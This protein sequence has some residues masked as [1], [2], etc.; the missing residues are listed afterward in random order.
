MTANKAVTFTFA[1]LLLALSALVATRLGSEFVPNLNEGDFAVLTVR[2]PGTSLTQSVTM[3]QQI[4]TTLKQR[5]PEIASVFARTGT[6]EIAS[7][8]MPPNVSDGYIM[9]K[10]ER[11]WPTPKKTREQLLA[12]IQQT[13]EQLPGN[14][15]EF[16]QPIQL[17]VNELISGVRSD[18]AIK[19]FGDDLAVLDKTAAKIAA[20][21]EEVAG[22]S[23]VKVEQSSGLPMLQIRIDRERAARLGLNMLDVQ[24]MIATATAG[25]TAGSL[26]E[27]D[28]RFD[29]TVRLPEHLRSD[30][31]ALK[32]LPVPLPKSKQGRAQ[33]LHHAG[34][35][36]QFR[37]GAGTESAQP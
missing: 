23:E 9:L 28:R 14:S 32:R 21:L 13:V 16:S 35:D 10:P 7:D 1:G 27:G 8:P 25:R 36:R 31:D 12:A 22:A 20:L 5:F 33:Q 6:A 11:D 4:E 34:R 26:F 37:A 18:V 17:R 2:I 29:I 19:V 24:E 3:Q 30:I 15:F